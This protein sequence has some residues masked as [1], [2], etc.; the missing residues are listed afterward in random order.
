MTLQVIRD[1]T[2]LQNGGPGDGAMTETVRVR[3]KPGPKPTG[4]GEPITVRLQPRQLSALDAWI[5]G[6]AR[7]T[8]RPAAIRAMVAAALHLMGK[9]GG[10]G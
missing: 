8:S 10:Q 7:P 3:K 6:R 5:A 2:V 1:T 4:K 9:D